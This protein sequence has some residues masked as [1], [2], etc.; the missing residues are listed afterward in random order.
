MINDGQISNAGEM[1]SRS[2]YLI[3]KKAKTNWYQEQNKNQQVLI[4]SNR[5][6][7]NLC[8]G[9][10]IMKYAADVPAANSMLC[11]PIHIYF[12]FQR[13]HVD[14]KKHKIWFCEEKY[15]K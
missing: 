8:L 14:F 6:I 15:F 5:A 1:A 4:L 10:S 9:A 3:S 2:E 13:A 11:C 7:V 12:F